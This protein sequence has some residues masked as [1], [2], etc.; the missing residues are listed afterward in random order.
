MLQAESL[1]L[2]R[3]SNEVLHDIHLQLSPGQVVGVLGPN[4]AGKSSLLGVLCGELAQVV[5]V[6]VNGLTLVRQSTKGLKLA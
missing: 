1:Y 3:G 2:R 5:T 6:M 4:G